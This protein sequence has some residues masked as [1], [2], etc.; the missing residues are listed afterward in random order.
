MGPAGRIHQFPSANPTPLG[1]PFPRKGP[2]A[3]SMARFWC[4]V[5][6]NPTAAEPLIVS[7][8]PWEGGGAARRR[9]LADGAPQAGPQFSSL[10]S[11]FFF[12]YPVIVIYLRDLSTHRSCSDFKNSVNSILPP[13]E[14]TING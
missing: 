14:M 10:K 3:E 7:L 4:R 1:S 12:E 9:R 6:R 11:Q 13:L 5:F 8:L 2:D